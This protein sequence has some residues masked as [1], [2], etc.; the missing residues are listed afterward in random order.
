MRPGDGD[1]GAGAGRGWGKESY[2]VTA[3]RGST[4]EESAGSRPLLAAPPGSRPPQYMM[5]SQQV[6]PVTHGRQ[7]EI[8]PGWIG[9]SQGFAWGAHSPVPPVT[10]FANDQVWG[11]P[12]VGVGGGGTVG[13]ASPVSRPRLLSRQTSSQGNDNSPTATPSPETGVV[14]GTIPVKFIPRGAVG[15]GRCDG[16]GGRG[17]DGS[18][19]AATTSEQGG[20][21]ERRLSRTAS[22]MNDSFFINLAD[23]RHTWAFGAIA[24]LIHNSSDAEATEVRVSLE[25]LGP[26]DDTN[27][28]VVDN[29]HGMTHPEM[30]QLFTVGKDYGHGST[31]QEGEHIGCNGVGFKQGVLRL[32]NTAVVVS[33]R[34][35][36]GHASLIAAI[37]GLAAVGA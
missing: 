17:G 23:K 5:T 24:E 10:S 19:G 18:G 20:V 25:D 22:S 28:V 31:A 9:A 1:A 33:V 15:G 12:V 34:G 37:F 27:F 3:T 26:K 32:G 6:G 35:E 21:E 30:A 14:N 11:S 29:G 13:N 16:D 7:S 2:A 36:R 4:L 8:P